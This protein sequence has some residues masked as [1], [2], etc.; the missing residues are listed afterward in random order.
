MN[1]ARNDAI[2]FDIEMHSRPFA[3]KLVV[4]GN[5]REENNAHRAERAFNRT[6]RSRYIH[7]RIATRRV[8]RDT[9]YEG[10]SEGVIKRSNSS[11]PPYLSGER[12]N[13]MRARAYDLAYSPL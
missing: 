7:K 9:G 11:S 3:T 2:I 13:S 10:E 1:Q 12:A 4:C 6:Q 5:K 8:P